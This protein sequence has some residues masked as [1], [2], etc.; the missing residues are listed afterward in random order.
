MK[1]KNTEF[2]VSIPIDIYGAKVL[3]YIGNDLEKLN[4]F[5]LAEKIN[6]LDIYGADLSS[7][8]DRQGFCCPFYLC[9]LIWTTPEN[10]KS[11]DDLMQLMVHESFHATASILSTVGIVHCL[12]SEEAFTYLQGFIVKELFKYL[13]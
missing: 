3:L 2:G 9:P 6:P 12:E 10:I 8:M 7:Y 1:F 5:L 11:K 4:K 13:K